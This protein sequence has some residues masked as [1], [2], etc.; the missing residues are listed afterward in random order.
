MV[1]AQRLTAQYMRACIHIIIILL[2]V[3]F[4]G[5]EQNE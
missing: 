1:T 2:D 4:C 5:E 3:Y